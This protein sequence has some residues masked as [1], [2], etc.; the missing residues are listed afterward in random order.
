MNKA[1]P[2]LFIPGAP[3]A[4]TTFLYSILQK[5]PAIYFPAIKELNYFSYE[6]LIQG[7]YYND[8]K[9]GDQIK[10]LKQFREGQ[11]H[12]YR[13]DGSVSYFAYHDVAERIKKFNPDAK[14]IFT[15]RNPIKRAFS[16]YQMDRRMGVSNGTF[17]ECIRADKSNLYYTQ[18]I[19]NSLYFE[20]IS[21]YLNC[22]D[23]K[24]I[25]IVFL[26]RMEDEVE[27]IF[28]FLN[29]D[30]IDLLKDNGEA[31]NVNKEP[32]NFM[33]RFI[34]KNRNII[35]RVK[36]FVPQKLISFANRLLYK[37]AKTEALDSESEIFLYNCFKDDI[38]KLSSMVEID[39]VE[40]WGLGQL[41]AQCQ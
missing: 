25:H 15:L 20:N 1:I 3:K 40:F 13:A 24:N 31:V 35:T 18:Y 10:Y 11:N 9:I 5:H 32:A 2:N 41:K 37:P 17:K 21:N 28:N 34:Q 7:S 23:K 4:G 19:Q 14:L 27:G 26:E 22:F 16:H 39:L 36:P 30:K 12:D 29:V 6:D 38:E 8:Y 33:A